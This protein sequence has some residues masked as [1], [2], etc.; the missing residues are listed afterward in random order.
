MFRLGLW[1]LVLC[2]LTC[3]PAVSQTA[4]QYAFRVVFTDKDGSPSLQDAA[5]FLSP[6]ALDRRALRGVSLDETDRPVTTAY[7]DSVLALT[8]GKLHVVSRWFNQCVVL[9]EDSSR[10]LQLQG[11]P[12]IHSFRVV[13]HYPNGLHLPSQRPAGK[14]PTE[15]LQPYPHR[16]LRTTGTVDSADYGY[17]FTQTALVN[18]HVLH[19]GGFWG[20]GMLIA[21]MDAG[22]IGTQTHPG[23]DSMRQSGRL[24]DM[25]D[26]VLEQDSVFHHDR[27]GT[28]VLGPIAGYIPGE[29]IGAAPRAQYALYRTEDNYGEQLIELDNLLAGVERADS[30]GADIINVSLGY[31]TFSFPSG[32][33]IDPAQ[34]DGRTTLA[35]QTANMAARKGMLFVCTAG[36]EGTTGLLTPGDADSAL[37]VGAVDRDRNPAGFSGWGPNAAGHVKPEVAA[38]GSPAI[39][40]DSSYISAAGG[41]SFAAPQI[42]GWAACLWQAKPS[43][44]PMEIHEAIVRSA[45]HYGHPDRQKGHGVPDFR[46]A[47]AWLKIL[48]TVQVPLTDDFIA[49]WPTVFRDNDIV[50]ILLNPR[51]DQQITFGLFDLGGRRIWQ[52]EERFKAGKQH[53]EL[54]FPSGLP[55]GMYLLRATGG[56]QHQTVKMVKY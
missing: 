24:V 49:T 13:A 34:M 1:N 37:T 56:M 41:T 28:S 53:Y 42:A 20:E 19:E 46:A 29:Y 4:S 16:Q 55:G 40:F 12:Y 36:N 25:H 31:N 8:Q 43:A 15:T 11:K 45:D 30:I 3:L 32:A 18:G 52:Y 2:L 7:I 22:F 33:N 26:F 54:L 35:A 6:R 10:I 23:F 39:V 38:L 44:S 14:S 47:G 48:D 17:A 51:A 9:L 27:H 50:R 5:Q 21:V